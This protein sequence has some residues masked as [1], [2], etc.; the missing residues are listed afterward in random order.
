[1]KIIGRSVEG[2]L[3][4]ATKEEL[5]NLVGVQSWQRDCPDFR[6]GMTIMVCE[7]FKRLDAMRK[8]EETLKSCADSLRNLADLLGPVDTLIKGALK[9]P[10]VANEDHS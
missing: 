4:E 6:P 9:E 2:Y 8:S 10:E 7:L 5:A 1:M 3:L